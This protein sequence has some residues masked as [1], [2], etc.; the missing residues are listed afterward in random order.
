MALVMSKFKRFY[1]KGFNNK[2]KKPPFKKGGQSSS[3]FKARCFE[4]ENS[5]L[6]CESKAILESLEVLK[7]Q[8][9]CSNNDFQKL[10]LEYKNLCEKISSPE[11][12]LIDYEV[13]KK[14]VNDL[15]LCI[16]RFTQ[17]KENFEKLLGLQRSPFDKNGIGYNH[18]NA[19][20]KRTYFIKASSSLS[21]PCCTYCGHKSSI[22]NMHSFV[23]L[24]MHEHRKMNFG[25]ITIEHMLATQSSSTKCLPCGCFI[26]KIFQHFEI[27]LVGVG[28]HID[29]GKIYNQNTFKRIGFER[30]D[31]GLFIR[32]GQQGSDDDDD[33][34]EDNGDEEGGNEPENMDKDETNEEDIRREMRSKRRQEKK[35][36]GSSLV[37]IGQLMARIIVMQSQLNGQLDDID[38]KIQN[39]LDDL[40]DRIVGIQNRVIRLERGGKDTDER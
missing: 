2:G 15:T 18:S 21:H 35:E 29:P 30:T 40:D 31:E 36:E 20:S 13:L 28:D 11:K 25:Y 24:A 6:I 5:R 37:D 17:G 38:G 26:T 33:D 3:L 4:Y 19:S 8:K 7:K 12:C 23:M 32:G 39:R 22:T 16:E 10:L 14:K 9:E 1:K 27:N 34:Q